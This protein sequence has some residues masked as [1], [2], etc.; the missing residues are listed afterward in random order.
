MS[1]SEVKAALGEAHRLLDHG[2]TT[3]EGIGASLDDTAGL[4]L[5]TLHD[6]RRAEA[7]KARQAIADAMR[8]VKLTLRAIDAA[9]E[10]GTEYGKVLG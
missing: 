8:E 10:S 5:A 4:M 3:T 6:S 9:Q 1:I 2:R 7:E